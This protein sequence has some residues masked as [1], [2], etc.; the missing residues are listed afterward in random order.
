MTPGSPAYR[1]T[2]IYASYDFYNE[3]TPLA[4]VDLGSQQPGVQ[5]DCIQSRPQRMPPL[6]WMC[7]KNNILSTQKLNSRL[8]DILQKE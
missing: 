7:Q 3:P 2:T 5:A 1:S 8:S 4:N 6:A